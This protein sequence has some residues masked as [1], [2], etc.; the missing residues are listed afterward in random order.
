M[1]DVSL[2]YLQPSQPRGTACQR[3]DRGRP[4]TRCRD[5]SARVNAQLLLLGERGDPVVQEVGRGHRGLGS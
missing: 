4:R 1:V 5:W 3:P 2:G